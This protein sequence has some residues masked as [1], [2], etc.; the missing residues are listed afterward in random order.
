[1]I[2]VSLFIEIVMNIEEE[3]TKLEKQESVIA[4]RKKELLDE[5]K[6][7][8]A[9]DAKLEKLFG[10]SGYETP[11]AFVEALIEKYDIKFTGRKK[12]TTTKRARTRITADIRD[13]IKQEIEA[14]KSKNKVSKETGISYVVITKVANGEYD[15]L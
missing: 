15:H 9:M 10:Q 13:S 7:A 8:E 6:K 4:Q 11:R 5:K 12:G 2:T 1:M 14:G 3:I